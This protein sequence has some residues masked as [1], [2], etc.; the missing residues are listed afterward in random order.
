[1]PVTMSFRQSGV[2]PADEVPWR[3][4]VVIPCG[5]ALL[6]DY[7]WRVPVWDN[8]N[9]SVATECLPATGVMI[10]ASD[11]SMQELARAD[12]DAW[13]DVANVGSVVFH[14]QY[15]FD[16]SV[17]AQLI[18]RCNEGKATVHVLSKTYFDSFRSAEEA[19]TV[20]LADLAGFAGC[21]VNFDGTNCAAVLESGVA[22]TQFDEAVLVVDSTPDK[23]YPT[24]SP[25]AY[26][27]KG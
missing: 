3:R 24:F 17:S 11:W 2:V 14:G 16:A 19:W 13:R 9:V 20:A 7:Y 4:L 1:M 22:S 25:V 27:L 26:A 6:N 10:I 23:S 5:D 8:Y 21:P 15:D 18:A 12:E